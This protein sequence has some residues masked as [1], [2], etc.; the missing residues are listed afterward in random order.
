M[1]MRSIGVWLKDNQHWV[2][3]AGIVIGLV[4]SAYFYVESKAVGEITLKFNTVKIV[5]AGVPSIKILDRDNNPITTNIFGCEIIIW[6]SGNLP[7]GEKSDRM[8]EPLTVTLSD[9]VKVVDAVVQDVRYVSL[10]A[11]NLNRRD[12]HISITWSQFD[13]GDAIKVFVIY[14]SDNQSSIEY[15]GRFLQTRLSDLSEFHEEYPGSYG[16]PAIRYDLDRKPL[17]TSLG[18]LSVVGFVLTL[19]LMCFPSFRR[20]TS[21]PKVA[22]II[23]LSSIGAMFTSMALDKFTSAPPFP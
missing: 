16:L 4:V 20:M 19:I 7:L 15:R 11:I 23:G 14:A 12:N 18:L 21:G 8:R 13:P 22:A 3:P 17:V 1:A 9:N 2:G 6:N 10:N 5:S